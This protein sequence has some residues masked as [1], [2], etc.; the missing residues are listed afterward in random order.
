[1]LTLSVCLYCL[2]SSIDVQCKSQC[3]H[4]TLCQR[5]FIERKGS[6]AL[7]CP[8]G[9]TLSRTLFLLLELAQLLHVAVC[10]LP[11][12]DL[13][14]EIGEVVQRQYKEFDK[15]QAGLSQLKSS[16]SQ[17]SQPDQHQR[18]PPKCMWIGYLL[19]WPFKACCHALFLVRVMLIYVIRAQKTVYSV[20]GCC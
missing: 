19:G 15:L 17:Q 8:K 18:Q 13:D 5:C 11:I 12:T 7:E 6:C 10:Q 16:Q 2:H 9:A 1:M 20:R 14:L 3:G 4:I